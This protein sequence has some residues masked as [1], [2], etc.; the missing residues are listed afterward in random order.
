MAPRGNPGQDGRTAERLIRK[1]KYVNNGHEG[2]ILSE[3]PWRDRVKIKTRAFWEVLPLGVQGML[4][5]A[6]LSPMIAVALLILTRLDPVGDYSIPWGHFF[7]GLMTW[8]IAVGF[9]WL[10]LPGIQGVLALWGGGGRAGYFLAIKGLDSNRKRVEARMSSWAMFFWMWVLA[11]FLSW[12]D[13]RSQRALGMTLG[14]G[15]PWSSWNVARIEICMLILGTVVAGGLSFAGA[16][17]N[18]AS[19]AKSSAFNSGQEPKVEWGVAWR[20]MR[21]A[22]VAGKAAAGQMVKSERRRWDA[23]RKGGAGWLKAWLAWWGQAPFAI[24]A[25]SMA[26]LAVGCWWGLGNW[27]SDALD[28]P[29]MI[30][31]DSRL[32]LS[33]ALLVAMLSALFSKLV[34]AQPGALKSAMWFSPEGPSLRAWGIIALAGVGLDRL[35]A[36]AVSQPEMCAQPRLAGGGFLVAM[37][38]WVAVVFLSEALA[39]AGGVFEAWA[40]AARK[41]EGWFPLNIARV[42]GHAMARGWTAAGAASAQLSEAVERKALENEEALAKSQRK[43]LED[44]IPEAPKSARRSNRL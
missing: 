3:R 12:I 36:W 5:W 41:K 37:I 20:G 31:Q 30:N 25:F 43:E 16:F 21:K 7:T 11:V 33:R 35:S 14:R 44:A 28:E 8:G 2:G 38:G 19:A 23:G 40:K 29:W 17:K 4:V 13:E 42:A 22:A 9:S 18:R 32:T 34:S 39:W 26:C 24:R 27:A 10:F 6:A 1:G 15:L